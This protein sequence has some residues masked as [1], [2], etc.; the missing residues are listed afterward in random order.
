[1]KVSKVFM[2][3]GFATVLFAFSHLVR[4]SDRVVELPFTMHRH[5]I[6]VKGG[7]N[8]LS[9]LNLVIDTG[10]SFTTVSTN[11]ARGLG[12]EGEREAVNAWHKTTEVACVRLDSVKLG[13]IRFDSVQA[14]IAKLHRLEGLDIDV[15]VGLNLLRR[16][17]ITID[18]ARQRIVLG[19]SDP[20]SCV[21]GFYPN[22]PFVILKLKLHGRPLSLI[23]DTGTPFLVF[24]ESEML[25]RG[26]ETTNHT[27][28]MHSLSGGY[29][30]Q[31]V[32]LAGATLN[33]QTVETRTAYLLDI[34]SRAYGGA[35]GIV[36]P[37]AL[38]LGKIQ[39]DF[40]K[41]RISWESAPERSDD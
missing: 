35:H 22:L 8:Q 39:L 1:M 40:V 28:Y 3:L 31:R 20:L 7:I 26:L 27:K 32:N 21:Q 12:L 18:Y 13:A 17:S 4:G 2:I 25:D 36:G 33:D 37:L 16:T 11:L 29:R 41:N 23:L 5:M 30:L 9:G 34:S 15:L 14:R 10:A 24:F 19:A 38:E 6:V